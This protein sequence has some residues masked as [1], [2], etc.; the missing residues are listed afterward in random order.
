MLSR[1]FS[2]SQLYY[3]RVSRIINIVRIVAVC[4][5]RQ[6]LVVPRFVKFACVIEIQLGLALAPPVN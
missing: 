1:P 6:M 3:D 4:P 5:L 2:A